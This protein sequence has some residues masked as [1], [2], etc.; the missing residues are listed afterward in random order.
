MNVMKINNLIILFNENCDYGPYLHV[1]DLHVPDL[2]VH[3]LLIH[4]L[5][6]HRDD[7]DHHGDEQVRII[8]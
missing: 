1:H 3:D 2:H 8:F 4:D 7:R 5:H 6:V